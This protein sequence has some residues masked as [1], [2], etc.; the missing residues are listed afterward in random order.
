M[1][2]IEFVLIWYSRLLSSLDLKFGLWNSLSWNSGCVC[3]CVCGRYVSVFVS[4]SVVS[5]VVYVVWCVDI[6]GLIVSD[7]VI[8][9]V[10]SSV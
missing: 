8:I 10:D 2:G 5:V 4:L 7:S 6:G 3:C 1:N 9:V